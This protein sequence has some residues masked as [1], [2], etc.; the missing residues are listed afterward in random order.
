MKEVNLPVYNCE[1]CKMKFLDKD[2]AI[3]CAEWNKKTNS[4]H[5]EIAKKAILK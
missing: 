4:C 3:K 5:V 2:L 1:E